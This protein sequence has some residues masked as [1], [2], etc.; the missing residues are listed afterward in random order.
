MPAVVWLSVRGGA[1]TGLHSQ[2]LNG[3]T[4]SRGIETVAMS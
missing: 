3:S 1:W 4:V 2:F